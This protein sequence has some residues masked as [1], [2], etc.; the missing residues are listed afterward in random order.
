M[1]IAIVAPGG[2]GGTFG[3]RLAK[4]GAEVV[5][6]ARGAHLAA[7]RKRGLRIEGPL[8]DDTVNIQASD[9]AATLGP[10]DIV[11]FAVKLYQAEEAARAAAPFFVS[12][13]IGITLLNGIGGPE[14]IASVLSGATILAGSAYVSAVIAAP[15][16]I[17]YVGNMSRI[18]LGAPPQDDQ[19][20]GAKVAKFVERCR[21]A[22]IA[23]E[24]AEDVRVVLWTKLLGLAANAALTAAARLPAGLLYQDPDVLAVATALVA[25]TAA[26]ARAAG[27]PLPDGV[28][29]QNLALLKSFP[30]GMY[31]SNVPRSR[32]RRSARSRRFLWPCGA[33]GTP[34]RRADTASCGALCRA[35]AA[36]RRHTNRCPEAAPKRV[37][38]QSAC[39]LNL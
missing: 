5:A 32:P 12:G 22:G 16:Q 3:G 4:A 27:V 39:L 18:V 29:A 33:G 6:L 38:T 10:A 25:E 36:P 17:R 7:I 37:F 23:A 31:A 34:T 20:A 15:G 28:A 35:E 2:V 8:G 11:L 21:H 14:A 19:L 24:I 30:A 26:V 13:T 9:D 1:R